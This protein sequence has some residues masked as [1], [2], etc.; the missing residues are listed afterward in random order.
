MSGKKIDKAVSESDKLFGEPISVYS[1]EQAVEDGIL[2]D[3]GK[4]ENIGIVFTTNLIQSL[5]KT[6]PLALLRKGLALKFERPDLKVIYFN[7]KKVYIDWNGRDL[8]FMLP[9]DY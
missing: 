7:G 2:A 1:K 5:K 9:E 6:E 4:I 8:T 3:F